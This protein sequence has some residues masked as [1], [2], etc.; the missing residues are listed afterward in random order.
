MTSGFAG[1]VETVFLKRIRHKPGNTS[2]K[3]KIVGDAVRKA[4]SPSSPWLQSKG[5]MRKTGLGFG[6]EAH[7][8]GAGE[9]ATSRGTE[10]ERRRAKTPG[11]KS[12]KQE[13]SSR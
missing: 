1:S 5:Q 4:E 11:S 3:G 8:P 10:A 6:H 2:E 12:E 9:L 13:K 7:G